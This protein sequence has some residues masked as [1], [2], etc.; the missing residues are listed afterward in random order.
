MKIPLLDGV[1]RQIQFD[2]ALIGLKGAIEAFRTLPTPLYTKEQ[3]IELL[4]ELHNRVQ[5][6]RH[7]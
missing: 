3:A 1:V 7:G 4:Q 5:E 6:N 2:G